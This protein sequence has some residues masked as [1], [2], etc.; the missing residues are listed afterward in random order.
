MLNLRFYGVLSLISLILFVF[1][2]WWRESLYTDYKGE[3][4][5]LIKDLKNGFSTIIDGHYDL[6]KELPVVVSIFGSN[7]ITITNNLQLN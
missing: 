4:S 7:I 3:Y 2:I 6:R 5:V 1:D